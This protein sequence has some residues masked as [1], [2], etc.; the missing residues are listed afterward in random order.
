MEMVSHD[1]RATA[2]T[3]V[4]ADTEQKQL[5]YVHGSGGTHAAWSL[6]YQRR[7]GRVPVAGLD[8]S[9]H[10]RSEDFS[11]TDQTALAAYAA[12]VAAVARRV[13]A[14][15]L[16]GHSL[17]GAVVLHLLLEGRYDPTGIVLAG[18]GA[19]LAVAEPLRAAL[20]TEFETAVEWLHKRDRLFHDPNREAVEQSKAAIRGVGQPVTRRDFRTA[21][22]FD[23]RKQLKTV[24]VP[25]LAVGGVHDSLTPPRYHEYLAAEL[26][27]CE[28]A[29]I[30]EAAHLAMLEQPAAFHAA[31]DTFLERLS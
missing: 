7:R 16:V 1:E 20:A 5:L 3:S 22:S 18:T 8:L 25:A 30:A 26:P 17:G 24:D 13:D 11:A 28:H 6:Q 2:Y 14:D 19:K 10:G 27:T 23:V 9:G 31:V 15:V 29:N 4:E 12:D 21:H